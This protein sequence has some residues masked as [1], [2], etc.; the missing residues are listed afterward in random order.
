MRAALDGSLCVLDGVDRIPGETIASL[1]RLLQDRRVFPSASSLFPA[2]ICLP[3]CIAGNWSCLTGLDSC[4]LQCTTLWP[5]K[6][7]W[8]PQV[9]NTMR[10]YVHLL[11]FYCF[12][13]RQR[14]ACFASIHPSVWL[15]LPSRPQR[16]SLGCIRRCWACSRSIPSQRWPCPRCVVV[17]SSSVYSVEYVPV[18]SCR[19]CCNTVS[20]P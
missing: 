4:R 12:S 15:L 14:R 2:L 17:L 13:Q 20:L 9:D 16:P 10:R 19:L 1:S 18:C 7:I 5:R 8:I 11:H 6:V 3:A